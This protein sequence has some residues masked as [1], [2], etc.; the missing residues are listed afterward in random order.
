MLLAGTSDKEQKKA[1]FWWT[2]ARILS[3]L[4]DLATSRTDKDL[5]ILVLRYQLR[6][7]QRTLPHQPCPSRWQRLVLAV[8]AAKLRSMSLREGTHW[9]QSILLFRPETILQWHRDLV[10]RKWT[11]VHTRASGRPPTDRELQGLILRLAR[12][13]PCWGYSRIQGE[14]GKLGY[15]VGRSTVRDVLKQHQVPPVNHRVRHGMTW[16][17]FLDHYRHQMLACDFF[18]VETLFLRTIYV[19][20]FIELATRRVH[21]AGCTEH[22]NSTWVVQQARQ[23]SWHLQDGLLPVRFLIH[24]RDTKFTRGFDTVFRSEGAEVIL[25][26]YR[27]PNANAVAERWVRSVR[28]ECL[29]RLLILHPCHLQRV[30]NEYAEYYNDRRPHQGLDQQCPAGA[31]WGPGNGDIHRREVLD[32]V[33]HDYYR[34]AA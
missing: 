29:D 3:L 16:R 12:E 17:V 19:L 4:I 23:L 8:L 28:E 15:T 13:N 20:F 27:A 9:R 11:F 34:S 18:T 1:M 10:R 31:R 6:V 2:L 33:I 24:D 26:P 21:I 5:E 7:L 14:L 25:T 22:P 30:L 32:G